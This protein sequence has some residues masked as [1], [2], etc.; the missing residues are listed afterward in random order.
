MGGTKYTK[1]KKA[2]FTHIRE[3]CIKPLTKIVKY[4]APAGSGV[5]IL[6]RDK[7]CHI[8]NIYANSNESFF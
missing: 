4:I 7:C 5:R 6:G 2:L 8:V 3:N 1:Y